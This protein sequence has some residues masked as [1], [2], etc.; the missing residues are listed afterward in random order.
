MSGVD[1]LVIGAG[2]AGLATA[3][4]LKKRALAF[5]AV[6]E[7]AR[8]GDTWRSRYRSLTLFTPRAFSALPGLPLAGDPNGYASGAEF[9]DYLERYAIA[10]GLNVRGRTKVVRLE[11]DR[12]GFV[13]TLST[14]QRLRAKAVIVATG[15]FQQGV[16]PAVASGFSHEV[17]QLTAQSYR[18]PEDIPAGP[19][20]VVGDG[21]S[22]RDIAMELSATHR[23]VL[24]CGHPRKLVPEAILGV[25]TWRWLSWLGLLTAA[26][27]S[28]VGRYMRRADPFPNR[29]RGL[30]DLRAAGIDI[31]PKLAVAAGTVARFIDDTAAEVR[32]V[33]WATGYRDETSWLEVPGAV[34]QQVQFVHEQGRSPAPGLYLVGRPWQ[35]NRASALI[36]GVGQDAQIIVDDVKAY[37][38]TRPTLEEAVR[39]RT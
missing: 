20:V 5:T 9:A 22:G 8:I 17:L 23:T 38:A 28:P 4:W 31:R 35:R 11:A 14:R 36:T 32:S 12:G 37:L 29:R 18:G 15:G 27:N 2:Q 24:A 25:S 3:F 6:D 16:V 30:D 26:T 7:G 33:I 34:D 21:A 10:K 1:V 19:V 39:S 13:A